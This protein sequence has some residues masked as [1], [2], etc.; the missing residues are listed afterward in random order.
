MET[1][2]ATFDKLSA[3][4]FE[5][6]NSAPTPT[7]SYPQA[8]DTLINLQDVDELKPPQQ[9]H[10]QQQENQAPFQT[11]IIVDNVPNAI[12]DWNSFVNPFATRSTS[13]AESS[14]SHYTHLVV[15]GYRQ[16]EG[17]D[18]EES[19]APVARMEVIRI[20]LVYVAH[21]SFIMFPM[22]VKTAFLHGTLKEDVC[23]CQT[24]GFIDADHPS[25]VYKLKNALYGLKQASK[26]WQKVGKLV[27]QKARLYGAVNRGSRM[28]VFIRLLCLS[29]LDAD[30]VNGLWLSLEIPIYYDLKL[31]IAIS[32]NL[33]QHSRT[34]HIVV[35][36]HF[37]KEHVEKGTIELYFVKTDYQLPDLFTKT[38]PVDR[39]NYLVR[40][41]GNNKDASYKWIKYYSVYYVVQVIMS[42]K[43]LRE[44]VSFQ[45]LEHE[46]GD[47]RSQ[48]DYSL[49]EVILSGDS[50]TLTRVV[51]G[52]VQPIAPTTVEQRLAKKNELKARGM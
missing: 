22:D 11:E 24:E 35:C 16:K 30:T 34:K 46:G 14:S 20:F 41:L 17:I 48:G 10:V 9:Q 51:G 39:L 32:C 8:L 37:I 25:H 44:I 6:R 45:D 2:N 49:W 40:L 43:I 18:F 4:A 38:L 47:T 13:V 50:P 12:L 31:A 1:M 29:H 7:N 27:I 23:V 19:F 28:C 21:K 3:M 15:R 33:V 36:Y 26:A 52:V 5:Q 42:K